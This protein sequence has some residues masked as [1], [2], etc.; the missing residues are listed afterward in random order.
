MFKLGLADNC[1]KHVN[2]IIA[3]LRSLGKA[4][5]GPCACLTQPAGMHG[6]IHEDETNLAPQILILGEPSKF[7]PPSYSAV[8]LVG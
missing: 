7:A 2:Q 6:G 8:P 1:T 3:Q 4:E 5:G